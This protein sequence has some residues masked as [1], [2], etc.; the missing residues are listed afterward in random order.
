[1]PG[2]GTVITRAAIPPYLE[3]IT[4]V[5]AEVQR[6]LAH[7]DSLQVV[8]AAKLTASYDATVRGGLDPLPAGLGTSADRF[9]SSLYTELKGAQ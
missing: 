8:L 2:H 3:M 7:G 1:V 4:T 6:R 9:V 5:R